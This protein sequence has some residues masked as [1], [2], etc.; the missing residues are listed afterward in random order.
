MV[1]YPPFRLLLNSQSAL[2]IGRIGIVDKAGS[3]IRPAY[4]ISSSGTVINYADSWDTSVNKSTLGTEVWFDTCVDFSYIYFEK[5]AS[6]TASG[7]YS[8]RFSS[9]GADVHGKFPTGLISSA[10]DLMTIR[11]NNIIGSSVKSKPV[12]VNNK[13]QIGSIK[14]G[15]SSG[16][17]TMIR[18]IVPSNKNTTII[19]AKPNRASVSGVITSKGRPIKALITVKV[20]SMDGVFY[21][22]TTDSDINGYSVKDIPANVL[23]DITAAPYGVNKLGRSVSKVMPVQVSPFSNYAFVGQTSESTLS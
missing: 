9:G 8:A 7:Y 17:K 20:M 18:Y 15:A 1:L 12:L 23:V 5:T 21:Y 4:C 3:I 19:E 11:T 14:T 2:T 16:Y 13:V 6:Q 10:L 22:I